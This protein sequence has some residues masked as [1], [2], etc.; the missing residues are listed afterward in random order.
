MLAFK[1]ASR[2]CC[3]NISLL[4]EEK[5]AIQYT[6]HD[7][8]Q[9]STVKTVEAEKQSIWIQIQRPFKSYDYLTDIVT[10]ALYYL[11]SGLLFRVFWSHCR[12]TSIHV[13]NDAFKILDERNSSI[14]KSH[15]ISSRTVTT[16]RLRFPLY[17]P[18]R[19]L[20]DWISSLWYWHGRPGLWLWSKNHKQW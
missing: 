15:K 2:E 7:M 12:P 6:L 17:H 10:N 14:G 11:R 8:Y 13:W 4:H 16:Q 3:Q 18:T 20:Q 1:Y 9:L 5:K 19:H